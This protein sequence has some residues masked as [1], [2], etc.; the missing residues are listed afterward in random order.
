M[1]RKY[2]P[3][4][5]GYEAEFASFTP[6]RRKQFIEDEG[7]VIEYR[8][9]KP[10][11]F[12]YDSPTEFDF[13]SF[14]ETTD[15]PSVQESPPNFQI[16]LKHDTSRFYPIAKT[17]KES[18]KIEAEEKRRSARQ[19]YFFEQAMMKS[20]QET[21]KIAAERRIKTARLK[22]QAVKKEYWRKKNLETK[23]EDLYQKF[24]NIYHN[25]IYHGGK[26]SNFQWY[27]MNDYK[28]QMENLLQQM[29]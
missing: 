17:Y 15:S 16:K 22:R 3:P 14:V 12:I 5:M 21:R 29:K 6:K 20:M 11:Q 1:K 18:L 8:H 4:P 13:E 2:V 28:K 25:P 24:K 19:Q 10:S 7:D 9:P 23:F 27:A 26:R